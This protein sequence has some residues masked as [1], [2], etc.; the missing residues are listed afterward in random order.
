MFDIL[1]ILHDARQTYG[2]RHEDYQRYRKHCTHRVH[3]LRQLQKQSKQ[4]DRQLT[5]YLYETE[6]SWAFGMELKQELAKSMETRQRHH[7]IKKLKRAT[8]HAQTLAELGSSLDERTVLDIKAYCSLMKG[9]LLLEQQHYKEAYESFVESRFIYDAFAQSADAEHESLCYSAIDTIDPNI[10]FCAYKL[11]LPGTSMTE[12][13]QHYTG[14]VPETPTKASMRFE[15]RQWTLVVHHPAL[16]QS[17]TESQQTHTWQTTHKLIKKI[18]K[19]TTKVNSRVSS[20]RSKQMTEELDRLRVYVEYQMYHQLIHQCL[21][22]IQKDTPTQQIKKYDSILRSIECCT[23][24]DPDLDMELET[25]LLFY[26]ASRCTQVAHIQ[27]HPAESLALYQQA[28]TYLVQVKQHLRHHAMPMD[29]HPVE[30]EIRSGLW[31]SRALFYLQQDDLGMSQLS[32]D[33]RPL[34]H[35]LDVYPPTI[36]TL[37]EFPPTLKPVAC[38]PFYFDLAA[39]SIQYPEVPKESSAGI[40]KLFGFGK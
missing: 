25:E 1:S 39:H 14:P 22:G 29:I 27:T 34:L 20:S 21:D 13:L 3:R 30:E 38:K 17:V 36:Q 6:R 10:R 11:Q 32:L 33:D 16:I 24:F 9:Y 28:Q 35:D 2:L 19:E 12:W 31:K 5:L 37:V 23:S 40:W 8:Q 18:I 26:K 4:E 7:L 15:W